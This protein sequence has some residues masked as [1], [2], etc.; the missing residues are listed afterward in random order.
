[1]ESKNLTQEEIN[2]AL[3][4]A[5]QVS[6]NAAPPQV[7]TYGQ[8]PPGYAPY[9]AYWQPPP[10]EY[11]VADQREK[12]GELTILRLPRRDWRDWFIMATVMSGVSFGLYVTAKVPFSGLRYID[13]DTKFPNSAISF[14]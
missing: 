7:Q 3:A 12:T 6:G 4:R 13:I 1:L 8:P 11:V 10:P 5:A 2:V 9:P 14:H